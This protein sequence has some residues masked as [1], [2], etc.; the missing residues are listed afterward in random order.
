M[1]QES[2]QA[3]FDFFL[4]GGGAVTTIEIKFFKIRVMKTCQGEDQT[5]EVKFASVILQEFL[6]AGH[7]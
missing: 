3:F 1:D 7:V 6:I 4:G 2:R 5:W